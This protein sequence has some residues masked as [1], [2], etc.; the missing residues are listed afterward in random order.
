MRDKIYE[1]LIRI[2]RGPNVSGRIILKYISMKQNGRV[3]NGFIWLRRG[4]SCFHGSDY[5]D[6]CLPGCGAL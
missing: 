3:W 2:L 1:V 4:T 5:E 6:S